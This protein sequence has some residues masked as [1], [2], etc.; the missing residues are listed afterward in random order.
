MVSLTS[1]RLSQNP[2]IHNADTLLNALRNNG[3]ALAVLD[4]SGVSIPTENLFDALP[5]LPVSL[6]ELR[7][8]CSFDWKNV[9][10]GVM[11]KIIQNFPNLRLLELSGNGDLDANQI[12]VWE[13]EWKRTRPITVQAVVHSDLQRNVL[14]FGVNENKVVS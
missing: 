10:T 12:T 13:S 7:L 11:V 6:Q 5:S 1:L 2:D 8:I 4:L 9:D 14:C 3:Y